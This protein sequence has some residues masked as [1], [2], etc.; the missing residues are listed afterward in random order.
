M[1]G[2]RAGLNLETDTAVRN[3]SDPL[4]AVSFAMR[5]KLNPSEAHPSARPASGQQLRSDGL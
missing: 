2:R 1:S 4:A 5:R 3:R